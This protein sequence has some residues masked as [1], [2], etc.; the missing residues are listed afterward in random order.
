MASLKDIKEVLRGEKDPPG[1]L[2][3][4]DILIIGDSFCACRI[5]DYDWPIVVVNKLTG[6]SY[7]S[8][9]GKGFTG[10]AWWSA[11]KLLLEQLEK[12]VPEVLIMTH[13]EMQRIPSDENYG[14][15]SG[16]VFNAEFYSNSQKVRPGENVVP[17]E[18]LLAGQSYYKYLFCKDFMQWAQTRWFYEIDEI[19]KAYNVPYVIHFH[20]F[21]PWDTKP[22]HIFKNGVTFNKALW[23]ISDDNKRLSNSKMKII[24]NHEVIDADLWQNNNTRNHFTHENNIVLA[25]QILEALNDYSN[26]ARDLQL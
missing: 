10:A 3:H 21:M 12:R 11:R 9:R 23:P 4:D 24:D 25:N 14:L 7:D 15:N 17:H 18:V 1:T 5:H 13:T 2:K 26:G 20:A 22:L 8:V 19:V 16:S 6:K